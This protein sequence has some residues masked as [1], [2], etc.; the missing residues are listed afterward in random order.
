MALQQDQPEKQGILHNKLKDQISISI[1]ESLDKATSVLSSLH[2]VHSYLDVLKT[3]S[4]FQSGNGGEG[5]KGALEQV[6]SIRTDAAAL[7]QT[8]YLTEIGL[9]SLHHVDKQVP[10]IGTTPSQVTLLPV[11]DEAINSS[12]PA[13]LAINSNEDELVKGRAVVE[14]TTH[15]EMT[16]PTPGAAEDAMPPAKKQNLGVVIINCTSCGRKFA[17]NQLDPQAEGKCKNCRSTGT[18]ATIVPLSTVSASVIKSLSLPSTSSATP[19]LSSTPLKPVTGLKSK[20]R[21]IS[22]PPTACKMCGTSFVYRRCLFRH[23]RE[24]HP[25][26]D[27]SNI[28]NYI[29]PDKT[30]EDVSVEESTSPLLPGSQN[31][32]MNVTVGSDVPP[33]TDMDESPIGHQSS[34]N[35]ILE[36]SEGEG[37]EGDSPAVPVLTATGN[38]RV[39]ACTICNKVFDRPY[40]LTRHIQIH[41]PN[42]PRVTCQVCDRSFTRHDTLE[43]H[44]MSMHSDERPYHCQYPSCKKNFATQSALVNH[45]KVHTDGKPYKCLECDSSFTLLLEYKLHMRQA[46]PDTKNLRCGDCYRVFPDTESL[47]THRSVEHLLECEICG[48]SFARLAYLQLHVQIHS[49]DSVY[50]CKFCSQGFDS[51]YAYKQHMKTHPENQR[52]KKGFHCQLCDKTFEEPADLIAHY[53]SQEHRDKATSLGIGADTTI[54]NTIEGDLSD[55]NAL[56]DEVAMSTD[57]METRQVAMGTTIVIPTNAIETTRVAMGTTPIAMS[58]EAMETRQIAIESNPVIIDMGEEAARSMA[59]NSSFET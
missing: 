3:M 15:P 23:L 58:T 20:A 39:Y 8:I 45:V 6:R 27:L 53:R 28:H 47:E 37:V 17:T 4:S 13:Q 32:S 30:S 5:L 34:L 42:R 59:E 57:A 52:N 48:K 40:R 21:K 24:N 29:E 2:R 10:N 38:K 1:K 9:Q 43:S 46:H 49:G 31:T 22:K 33:S 12:S 19:V 18:P 14:L 36:L 7:L 44:M 35:P 55:M 51:E 25:G 50:N 26:I 11:L 16:E 56:V 54:L 41:D